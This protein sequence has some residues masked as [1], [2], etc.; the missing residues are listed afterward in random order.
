MDLSQLSSV[1]TGEIKTE[2]EFIVTCPTLVPC[3]P[4]NPRLVPYFT[5]SNSLILCD[6]HALHRGNILNIVENLTEGISKKT[7]F[8][9]H[10][11][12]QPEEPQ[13][14]PSTSRDVDASY[15]C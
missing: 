1:F 5:P 3:S 2:V 9:I 7:S 11:K 6:A 14:F 4:Y 8:K 15:A 10:R 12:D 13:Q